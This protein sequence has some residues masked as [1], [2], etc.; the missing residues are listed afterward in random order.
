M[1]T[2]KYENAVAQL[3]T[4]LGVDP[5]ATPNYRILD[6][7]GQV[8]QLIFTITEDSERLS[9]NLT[10]FAEEVNRVNYDV[11]SPTRSSLIDDI[12]ENTSRLRAKR[13]GL[14]DLIGAI[15][16][17]DAVKTFRRSIG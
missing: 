8:D 5:V 1:K 17:D 10:R 11:T 14:Y 9:Q 16:G 3:F 2:G 4:S 13:E 7:A 15:H 12:S 6:A